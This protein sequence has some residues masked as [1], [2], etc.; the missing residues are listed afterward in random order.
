[1]SDENVTKSDC[2]ACDCNYITKEFSVDREFLAKELHEAGRKAVLAGNT[3]AAEKC[4][5][6]SKTFIEWDDC[7]ENVK[8]GRRIQADYLLM[9]FKITFV[10]TEQVEGVP[11][12]ENNEKS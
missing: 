11:P 5:D 6:T 7:S 2:A 10:C 8:E 3:V 9:R 12:D 1:M 4:G